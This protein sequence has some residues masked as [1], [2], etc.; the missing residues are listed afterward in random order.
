MIHSKTHSD[1]TLDKRYKKMD[2]EFVDSPQHFFTI[3]E[4]LQKQVEKN[5]KTN[6][7]I[8]HLLELLSPIVLFGLGL[9]VQM[10]RTFSPVPVKFFNPQ[11]IVVTMMIN[12]RSPRSDDD[13]SIY[14]TDDSII[15]EQLLAAQLSWTEKDS[16][17]F[18]NPQSTFNDLSTINDSSEYYKDIM[19]LRFDAIEYLIERNNKLIDTIEKDVSRTINSSTQE[20]V[21]FREN[22]QNFV[23]GRDERNKTIQ[24]LNELVDQGVMVYDL[25]N[26]SQEKL[27][28]RND[29][30]MHLDELAK[31]NEKVLG[32]K[33][34]AENIKLSS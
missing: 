19:R 28:H 1:K 2:K 12:S 7:F 31:E 21:T 14:T 9:V 24:Y 8:E 23:E 6:S 13:V 3:E 22:F 18:L 25:E 26:S 5:K 10:G 33:Q 32:Y 4:F 17:A 34:V 29:V 15:D 27:N 11:E 16:E 30:Q 20:H